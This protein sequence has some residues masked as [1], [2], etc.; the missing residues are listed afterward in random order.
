MDM[1]ELESN[2]ESWCNKLLAM[3]FEV[4]IKRLVKNNASNIATGPYSQKTHAAV[5]SFF[6]HDSTEQECRIHAQ[7]S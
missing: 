5:A 3:N 1:T 7:G 4:R 2:L 6:L